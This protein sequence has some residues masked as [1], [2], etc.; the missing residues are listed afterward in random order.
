[1][2]RWHIANTSNHG[3]YRNFYQQSSSEYVRRLVMDFNAKRL[4]YVNNRPHFAYIAYISS[5]FIYLPMKDHVKHQRWQIILSTYGTHKQQCPFWETKCLVI[6]WNL[7][8]LML[9]WET[10]GF[11]MQ[12]IWKN[13]RWN[14]TITHF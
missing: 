10:L 6:Y 13:E 14:S 9:F 8:K 12:Q 11:L 4:C 7:E 5:I 1:M 2:Q 3:V